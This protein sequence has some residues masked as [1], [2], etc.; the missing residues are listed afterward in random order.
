MLIFSF[1]FGVNMPSLQ[2][3]VLDDS[4]A[5]KDVGMKDKSK[6]CGNPKYKEAPI[7]MLIQVV[8]N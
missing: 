1:E 4:I 7:M 3:V 5:W 6:S 2:S 8:G